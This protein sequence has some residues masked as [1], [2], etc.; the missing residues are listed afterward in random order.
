[1]GFA[2]RVIGGTDGAY[3]EPRVRKRHG[4]SGSRKPAGRGR[5]QSRRFHR[6]LH[7]HVTPAGGGQKL[8]VAAGSPNRKLYDRLKRNLWTK[9]QGCEWKPPSSIILTIRWLYDECCVDKFPPPGADE[10]TSVLWQIASQRPSTRH[11][12]TMPRPNTNLRM[13]PSRNDSGG[14]SRTSSNVEHSTPRPPL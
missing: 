11:A 9:S 5:N 6:S 12:E 14:C 10:N 3:S 4:Q 7:L 13:T 2:E 1:M 8:C